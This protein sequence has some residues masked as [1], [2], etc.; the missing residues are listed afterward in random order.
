MLTVICETPGTL[1]AEQRDRPV[2]AEGQVLV[3][4]KRV[5]VCGTDL[6]I[7]TGNQPFLDYPRVM[8]HEL[9]GV[10]EDAAPGGRLAV[11]DVVYVMPYLS[12]GHCV[13][14]R[15]GKTNCCVNMAEICRTGSWCRSG[16]V[17]L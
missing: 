1:K 3:R 4:V 13:A 12:C 9:S 16:T 7:F 5:G 17:A 10:V 14:C 6:H 15:Q 2:R 8:G 11:G